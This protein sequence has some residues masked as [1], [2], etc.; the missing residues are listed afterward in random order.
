MRVR[1]V[2]RGLSRGIFFK[3]SGYWSYTISYNACRH[4]GLTPHLSK[5]LHFTVKTIQLGTTGG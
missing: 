2:E 1:Q 5:T 3:Q 4:W